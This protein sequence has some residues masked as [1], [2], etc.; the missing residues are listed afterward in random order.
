MFLSASLPPCRTLALPTGSAPFRLRSLP[1]RLLSA[2]TPYRHDSVPLSVPCTRNRL[3]WWEHS[4]NGKVPVTKS[5][6]NRLTINTSLFIS[7]THSFTLFSR[8]KFFF[9]FSFLQTTKLNLKWLTTLQQPRTNWSAPTMWTLVYAKTDLDEVVGP[10][11][12]ST[13]W[14]WNSKCSTGMKTNIFDWHETWKWEKQTLISLFD[15][16]ISWLLR[17]ETLAKRKICPLC[18]WNY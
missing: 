16:G 18:K 9:F 6:R 17:S 11:I 14:T 4:I 12:L 1:P 15:W 8:L 7:T 10:K 13:T 5:Y 3:K 2:R